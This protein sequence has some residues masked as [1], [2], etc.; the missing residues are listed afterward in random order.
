MRKIR[1][2]IIYYFIKENLLSMKK[3]CY[4]TQKIMQKRNNDQMNNYFKFSWW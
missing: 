4:D 1:M 3:I 2:R